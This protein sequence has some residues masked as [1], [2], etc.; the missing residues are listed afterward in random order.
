MKTYQP[1]VKGQSGQPDEE[2]NWKEEDRCYEKKAPEEEGEDECHCEPDGPAYFSPG[3]QLT[4]PCR[5]G[6]ACTMILMV[7]LSFK[8]SLAAKVVL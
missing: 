1:V 5:E 6:R 3:E 4:F 8:L 2:G 7:K